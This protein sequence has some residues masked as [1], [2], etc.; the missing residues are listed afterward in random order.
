MRVL[1]APSAWVR[2][3][4]ALSRPTG[5]RIRCARLGQRGAA[6]PRAEREQR[7][8]VQRLECGVAR[9]AG[10]ARVGADLA[11]GVPGE[12]RTADQGLQRVDL[13]AL[14]VSA[15]TSH[16]HARLGI[17]G[18]LRGMQK[19]V[20][21]PGLTQRGVGFGERTGV[22]FGRLA[23]GSGARSREGVNFLCTH[24]PQGAGNQRRHR[25]LLSVRGLRPAPWNATAPT[26]D[27]GPRLQIGPCT[28]SFLGMDA[29][30]RGVQID[31][32]P[33]GAQPPS[34]GVRPRS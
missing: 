20:R 5:V 18:D 1:R 3:S 8:G 17:N 16:G 9:L 10:I 25:A 13:T 27:R 7:C 33:R 24:P 30:Q 11:G 22:A 34:H 26:E 15:S 14:A 32:Q 19:M 21:W 29:Q 2:Q 12:V 28:P 4:I 31:G 6:E 23:L